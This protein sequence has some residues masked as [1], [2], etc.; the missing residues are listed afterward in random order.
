MRIA[1]A[2]GFETLLEAGLKMVLSGL[3]SLEEVRRVLGGI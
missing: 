1:R 2:E 3:T